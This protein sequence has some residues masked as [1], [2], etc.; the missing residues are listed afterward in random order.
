MADSYTANLNLTKPE[1]GASRDTW[2]TK[3]NSDWDTVDAVFAAGGTGTSVGLN[4]G[5]GKTLSVAGTL[6]TTGAV[7][8][9][10]LLTLTGTM[11]LVTGGSAVDSALTLKST[12]GVGTS[13]SI[14]FKVGNNGA[15]T[16]M[17]INT[18]GSVGIGSTTLTNIGLRI[19]KSITGN[20]TSFGVYSDG[21]IQPD[22]TG[23]GTYFGT[24]ASA[25]SGTLG[26]MYHYRTAQASLGTATFATQVGFSA[27]NTLI[28]AT[29]NY[30]FFAENTAAVTASKTAYGFYSDVDTATGGGTAY[31]FY[32]AGTA[33]NY[34]EGGIQKGYNTLVAT[35]NYT[36]NPLTPTFQNHGSTQATSNIGIF[37]WINATA[38]PAGVVLSKSRGA[39]AGTRAIVLDNDDIGQLVFNADDGVN[40]I[41][42]AAILAEV[43]DVPGLNDM[44]GRLTFLT[45]PNGSAVPVE[46][47]RI[48][49]DGTITASAGN[50]L[51]VQGTSQTVAASGTAVSFSGIPSWATRITFL[52][53]DLAVSGTSPII[54]Q[55]GSTTFSTSGYLG[56]GAEIRATPDTGASGVGFMVSPS[57]IAT[58]VHNGIMIIAKLTSGNIWVS[59]MA[60]GQGST[61]QYAY[62][63][64]NKSPTLAG[65]LDRVRITTVAGTGTF[66]GTFNIHYE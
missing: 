37:N 3:T 35:K 16:A 9:S 18:S 6:A 49:N 52:F 12:S 28:G 29:N 40:F 63:S 7:N 66:T 51:L 32:A 26:T 8:V 1:V 31:G 56:G 60:A 57:P 20:A 33:P 50:V 13:D 2:G 54:V 24:S 58:D 17:T 11:P 46:R 53:A 39:T 64:G 5:V 15:T 61:N 62:V 34:F 55:L 65:V 44:P 27:D 23:S 48:S 45:T 22:V 59:A 36:N 42:A 41:A 43:D 4:V 14:A 19:S 47:M 10:G 25:T 21:Q 38:N 30:G